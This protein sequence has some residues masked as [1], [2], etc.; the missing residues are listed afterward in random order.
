MHI[1]YQ[2]KYTYK[3]NLINHYLNPKEGAKNRQTVEIVST[4][5]N[6]AYI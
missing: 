3:L 5:S 4:A 1:S 6:P 2:Y